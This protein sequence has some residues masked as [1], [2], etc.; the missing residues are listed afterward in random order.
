MLVQNS[1]PLCIN[2]FRNM[3]DLVY[4]KKMKW[5]GLL[6]R[7]L[8]SWKCY[9]PS[10]PQRIQTVISMLANHWTGKTE[11]IRLRHGIAQDVQFDRLPRC[12]EN[13][14]RGRPIHNLAVSMR[15]FPDIEPQ[16][17]SLPLLLPFGR[18]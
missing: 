6:L 8:L 2:G 14:D 7:T 1:F 4:S 5:M 11:A 9:L 15:Q 10:R 17:A 18:S 12:P 16:I 3:P 13:I